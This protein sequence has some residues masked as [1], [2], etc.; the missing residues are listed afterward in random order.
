MASQGVATLIFDF[1]G[2]GFSE[3]V[4]DG[5]MVEDIVD[6]W[7]VLSQFPEVD[8]KRMGLIGHSLG[9]MPAIIAAENTP[10]MVLSRG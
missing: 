2:Y 5:R 4:A 6:A 3:G 1:H 7:N 9:A 8:K 10:S